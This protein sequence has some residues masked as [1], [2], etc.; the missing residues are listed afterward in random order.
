MVNERITKYRNQ[1]KILTA[2][3]LVEFITV[4]AMYVQYYYYTT[5]DTSKEVAT[6]NFTSGS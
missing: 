3:Q 5:N 6:N 4:V 2:Q 1:L